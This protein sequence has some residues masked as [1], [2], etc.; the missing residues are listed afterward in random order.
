MAQKDAQ[1]NI[2][3]SQASKEDSV[4]MKTIAVLGM[5]F[6]PGTFLAVSTPLYPVAKSHER[7]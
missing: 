1:V 7:Y 2:E 6:L 3:L 4:A 5:F